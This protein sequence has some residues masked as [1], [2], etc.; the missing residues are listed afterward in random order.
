[1]RFVPKPA[2]LLFERGQKSELRVLFYKDQ[3]QAG[4]LNIS[5]ELVTSMGARLSMSTRER[6]SVPDASWRPARGLSDDIGLPDLSYLNATD[7]PAGKRGFVKPVGEHLQFP[8]GS[9]ARFWGTNLSAYVLFATPYWEVPGVAKRLAAQGYNLVRLHHHD[10]SWVKPNIFGNRTDG[11]LDETQAAKIDRW[12]KCLRDEG[13]YIWL[14]MHVGRQF[15]AAD[16]IDAFAEISKGKPFAEAKGFSYMNPGVQTAMKRFAEQYL[17]RRSTETG[18]RAVDDPA[19]AFVALTNENDLTNHFGNV[20]LPDKNVPWHNAAY[21]AAAKQFAK[22]HE[23]DPEKT[24]RS[25]EPGPSKI[26]LNDVERRF[27]DDQIR[28]LRSIGLRALISTTSTWGDNPIFSLPALAVGDIVDVH[29]YG[30]EGWM[31]IDPSFAPNLLHWMQAGKLSGK[32]ATVSEWNLGDVVAMDRHT[33]PLYLSANAVHQGVDALMHYAYSQ[34]PFGQAS[35]ASP[36]EAQTDPAMAYMMPLAALIYRRGLVLPARQTVVYAP[37]SE[38][39]FGALAAPSDTPVLRGIGEVHRLT[40]APPNIPALPWLSA[41]LGTGATRAPG[42]SS[43]RRLT[44]PSDTALQPGATIVRSDTGELERDWARRIVTINAPKVQA[45]MGE[46]A[47]Q[48]IQL[49]DLQV[50]LS[51]PL[52]TVV[53][54]SLDD[55]PLAKSDDWVLVAMGR[56]VAGDG[57]RPPYLLEPVQGI[58]QFHLE[59]PMQATAVGSDGQTGAGRLDPVAGQDGWMAMDLGTFKGKGSLVIRFKKLG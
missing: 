29:S 53:A 26:F 42:G 19:V 58:V 56:V 7:R 10:S 36:W 20:L 46:L 43:V 51:T 47:G 45:A 22:Q 12:I 27:N 39:F 11:A 55:K 50:R 6:L 44:Q 54:L 5:A 18:L 21:M 34:R 23:L 38:D 32:P 1:M 8:D 25:W 14:D 52:A 28:H 2:A 3:I 31:G 30:S 9:P 4:A 37:R 49:A 15:S 24:W 40:I 16:N 33:L 41:A 48:N 59:R 57:G 17:T 13:I 35:G